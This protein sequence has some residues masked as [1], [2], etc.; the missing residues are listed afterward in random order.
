[1]DFQGILP[2]RSVSGVTMGD[3]DPQELVPRLVDLVADGRLPLGRLVKQYPLA[4]ID[5][6]FADMHRGVTV[7]PVIVH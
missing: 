6:A 3:A 1:V 5:D 7:K 4:G 2:G